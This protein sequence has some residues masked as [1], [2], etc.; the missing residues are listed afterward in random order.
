MPGPNVLLQGQPAQGYS[1]PR[2]QRWLNP[3]NALLLPGVALKAR[4]LMLRRAKCGGAGMGDG[5]KPRECDRGLETAFRDSGP[6]AVSPPYG[7]AKARDAAEGGLGA[8]GPEPPQQ[9]VAESQE[10]PLCT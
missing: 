6:G 10:P 8:C 3:Q 5:R 1:S 7:D 9:S 2:V 4:A